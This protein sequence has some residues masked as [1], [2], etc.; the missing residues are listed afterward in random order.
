MLKKRKRKFLFLFAV[1]FIENVVYIYINLCNAIYEI[2][3]SIHYVSSVIEVFFYYYYYLDLLF[4]FS[5]YALSVLKYVYVHIYN[6]LI[7]I[8]Y[9]LL[10]NYCY[11]FWNSVRLLVPIL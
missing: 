1:V 4:F 3:N 10:Y 8:L 9:H 11:E 5:I 2:S 7:L 6:I